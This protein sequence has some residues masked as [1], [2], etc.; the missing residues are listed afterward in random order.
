MKKPWYIDG[1]RFKCT[2][3]GRCCT[4]E[5]GAVF[6]LNEEINSIANSLQLTRE[7]FIYK[8]TR[9]L[10]GHLALIED[11]ATFDCIFLKN[12]KCSIYKERPSQCRKYPWWK[13]L[14]KRQEDWEKEKER[15][16]GIDHVDG[17]LFTFV[18]IRRLVKE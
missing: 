17:D 16:E 4:G 1:L 2:G 11:A 12:N 8:Y 6:L 10:D 13:E 18:E 3:C 9:I 15:C 5:P 7:E 14:I